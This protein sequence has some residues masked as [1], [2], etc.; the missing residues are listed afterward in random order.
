MQVAFACGNGIHDRRDTRHAYPD[1]AFVGETRLRHRPRR[2]RTTA[3]DAFRRD[4][5][6]R[7]GAGPTGLLLASEL[8]RRGVTC[9]LID[10]HAAPLHWDRATIVHPRSLEVF[11]SLGLVDRFLAVGVKQR[12]AHLHS[13]GEVLGE[14]DL[15]LC[16]SRYPFNIGISEEVTE[17]VLTDYLHRHGGDVV[18]SSRLV[19]LCARDDGFAARIERDGRTEEIAADWV[20]GCDGLHSTTRKLAGIELAGHD[21][22]EPWAV[23][24]V[25][26]AG[27]SE[28]YE[29]IYASLEET[30]VI[31]T[32]PC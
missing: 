10:S 32:T 21:I 25:T 16:G 7:R 22:A 18:R 24:D 11:E 9:R 13:W 1:R 3:R 29:A 14:I 4:R 8:R 30:P 12:F 26:L 31:P 17:S 6:R 15:S 20:V 27:W 28:P 5:P 2:L 23:F 19:E